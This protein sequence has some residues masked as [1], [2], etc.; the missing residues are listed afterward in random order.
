MISTTM[1]AIMLAVVMMTLI[2]CEYCSAQCGTTPPANLTVP[3][4]L[5][6]PEFVYNNSKCFTVFVSYIVM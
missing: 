2:V 6:M 1:G 3:A 5:T 4:I